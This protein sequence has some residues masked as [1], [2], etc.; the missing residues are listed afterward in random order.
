MIDIKLIRE[1]PKLVKESQRKRNLPERII[2]D[3]LNLDK[4]W[5]KTKEEA[6]DLRSERNKI[7]L[8]INEFKKEK[9]DISQLIKRAKE[10][11]ERLKQLEE[12]EN[13]LGSKSKGL[14]LNLPNII[15]KSVPIG[16]ASKNKV[17]SRTRFRT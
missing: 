7:S 4:E 13:E 15:D 14:L 3:L 17:L 2:D 1:N 6:D 16:D 11:P 10:I 5:R 8:Q 9:K 12:T